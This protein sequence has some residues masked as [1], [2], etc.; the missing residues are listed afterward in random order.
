MRWEGVKMGGDRIYELPYGDDI[1]LLAEGE[2]EMRSMME[3]M[4]DIWMR[5]D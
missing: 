1:V 2:G 5:K 3:R 4:K